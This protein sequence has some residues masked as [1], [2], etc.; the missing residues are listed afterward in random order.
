MSEYIQIITTVDE[1]EYAKR[2]SD[3]L[4]KERLAACVQIIG[5]IES[6]Y[7]WEGN[8]EHSEEFICLIKSKR[9]KFKEVEKAVKHIHPYENP[10]I[11][12]VPIVNGSKEYLNWIEEVLE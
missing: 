6:T 8:I 7:R 12:S 4:V 5:P 9:I 1:K 10:E 2:I 3:E 11:I